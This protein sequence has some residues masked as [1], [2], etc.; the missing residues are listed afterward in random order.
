MSKVKDKGT[1]TTPIVFIVNSEHV[2]HLA[3][4]P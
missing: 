3:V 1:R 2:S 4:F